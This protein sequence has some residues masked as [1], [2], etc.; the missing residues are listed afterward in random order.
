MRVPVTHSLIWS[1]LLLAT[2]G[3]SGVSD[4][5]ELGRVT[6]TVTLDGQPLAGVIVNFQPESGRA[7]TAETDSKGYYDLVYIYGSNG[8]KV[9]KNAVSFRW[10]DGSEGK[11]PIPA[12]YAGKSELTVEVQGGKNQLNWELESK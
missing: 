10:P 3:C 4:Q 11:K 8:A 1:L 9:G 5:P 2:A 12:K 7:A 6:G